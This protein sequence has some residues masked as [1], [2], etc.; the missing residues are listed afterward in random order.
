STQ[1]ARAGRN[2]SVAGDAADCLWLTI[3]LNSLRGAIS[4]GPNRLNV[5][6]FFPQ[7]NARVAHT[8]STMDWRG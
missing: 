5:A 1:S 7:D 8:G 3:I 2:S 6:A 4:A